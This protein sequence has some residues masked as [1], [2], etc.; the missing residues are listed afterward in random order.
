MI[1]IWHNPRCSKSRE[2][3]NLLMENGEEVEVREYLKDAPSKAEIEEILS[4]LNIAPLAL[5]RKG[6]AIYKENFKGK[7]LTDEEY[8]NAMVEYPKLIERPIVIKDNKAV[9]GRPPSLVLDL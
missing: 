9:I 3:L 7:E 8:I 6:E 4:M 2:S 5:I 1:K